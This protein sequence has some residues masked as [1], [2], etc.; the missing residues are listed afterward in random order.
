MEL[1]SQTPSGPHLLSRSGGAPD[2]PV[3]RVDVYA[4]L[5][6]FPKEISAKQV[7]ERAETSSS[8]LRVLHEP[9][10]CGS[11][12]VCWNSWNSWTNWVNWVNH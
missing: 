10:S 8:L 12:W 11:S 3:R 9:Q 1:T 4:A 6:L 2:S 5:G 7:V